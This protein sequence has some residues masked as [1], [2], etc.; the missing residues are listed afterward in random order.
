MIAFQTV[1]N[2]QVTSLEAENSSLKAENSSL[3][4]ELEKVQQ[5]S[6]C[7]EIKFSGGSRWPGM[8]APPPPTKKIRG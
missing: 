8:L 7:N 6:M 3:K 5:V 4:S 2:E 1:S